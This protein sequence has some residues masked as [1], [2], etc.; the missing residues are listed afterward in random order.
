M[1]AHGPT[2]TLTVAVLSVLQT[3][4]LLVNPAVTVT[5][6]NG[7]CVVMVIL[8]AYSG[9][10]VMLHTEA[11]KHIALFTVVLLEAAAY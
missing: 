4:C 5:R 2:C 3:V 9:E 1:H 11:H 7:Q 8:W 6:C 10:R